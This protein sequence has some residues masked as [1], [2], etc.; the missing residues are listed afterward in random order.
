MCIYTTQQL[1]T[2]KKEKRKHS[3]KLNHLNLEFF[4]VVFNDWGQNCSVMIMDNTIH[5]L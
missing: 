5:D 4:V 2:K 3:S 1:N